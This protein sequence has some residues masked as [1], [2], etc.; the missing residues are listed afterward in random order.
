[1]ATGYRISLGMVLCGLV[2]G[3]TQKPSGP[4]GA[5]SGGSSSVDRTGGRGGR[6]GAGGSGTAGTGGSGVGAAGGS[7]GG[8]GG[9]GGAAGSAGSTADATGNEVA[10][11]AGASEAGSGETGAAASLIESPLGMP[12]QNLKDVGLFPAFPDMTQIHPRA[13]G[14]KPRH[15]LWSNGLSKAR[16]GILPAGQK[17]NS[18]T[19][20]AWDFPIGT[21]FFK[22]FFQDPGAGGKQRPVETRLIRRKATEGAPNEQ[23]EFFVWQ[24]NADGTSATL[25]GDPKPHSGAS[26]RCWTMVDHEIP[27]RS[28][29]WNCHIGNKSPIIGFDELRLNRRLRRQDTNAITRGDRTRMAHA[30]SDRARSRDHGCQ[31]AS[32][33]GEGVDPRQLRPLPQRRASAGTGRALSSAGSALGQV[34]GRHHRQA[35]NDSWNGGR[36]PN[37]S[38]AAHREHPVPGNRG[39]DELGRRTAQVKMMPPAGV[40]VPD[41]TAVADCGSGSCSA[42]A[43]VAAALGPAVLL[44]ATTARVRPGKDRCPGQ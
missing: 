8:G 19:R 21:L 42:A 33:T 13:V 41:A 32:A 6:G 30:A 15:E 17:I 7:G 9:I 24:W 3:C 28:E 29:C 43:T 34:H 27:R 20:D 16:F 39:P 26:H 44:H 14:F 5:G 31:H 12:P 10:T 38:W 37:R 25:G 18:S 4:G 1:M 36:H 2:L 40:K 22:T 23:W 35:D 11:E